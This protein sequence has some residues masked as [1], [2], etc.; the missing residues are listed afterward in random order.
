MSAAS[1]QADRIAEVLLDGF[2][3]VHV[4]TALEVTHELVS[5]TP[6][7]TGWARANWVPAIGTAFPG[8]IGDA[9]HK[10]DKRS[11]SDH[12]AAGSAAITTQTVSVLGY[13]LIMGSIFVANNVPYISGPGSLDD[14]HSK[15]QAAGFIRRSIEDAVNRVYA[16]LTEV[17]V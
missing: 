12:A 9:P 2:A 5:N 6:V 13:Q 15:Q 17:D 7:D 16:E 10:G 14:G 1:I 3:A 4:K 11:K 8:L